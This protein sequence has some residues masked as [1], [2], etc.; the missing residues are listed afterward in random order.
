[1]IIVFIFPIT[2]NGFEHC[3]IC[4]VNLKTV[5]NDLGIK[6]VQARLPLV[7]TNNV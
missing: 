2:A 3:P 4:F 7:K 5:E 6:R 1:M